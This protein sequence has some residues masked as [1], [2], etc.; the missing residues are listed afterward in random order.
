LESQPSSHHPLGLN[1]VMLDILKDH[2]S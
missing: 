2:G 1:E